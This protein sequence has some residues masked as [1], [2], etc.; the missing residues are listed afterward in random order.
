VLSSYPGEQPWGSI[1][2]IEA[3]DEEGKNVLLNPPRLVPRISPEELLA[4]Y[5]RIKAVD[6]TRPVFLT[7]NGDFFEG[8]SDYDETTRKRLYPQYFQAADV[9]GYDIYPIFGWGYPSRLTWIAEAT[10]ELVRLAG[11]RPVY[12]WIE[13]NKGSRW[14]SPE[15]QIDVTPQHTRAEVWMAIIRGAT[16]VGYFTHQ[17]VPNYHQFAPKEP[18]IS[19]LRRLNEQLTRLAPAILAE[20]ARVKITMSLGDGLPCH[21]KATV[22]EG[23]LYIFAQNIDL[24]PESEKKRQFEPIEPRGGRAVFTVEGLKVGTRIEV[25]DEDRSIIAEE[26]RF[27]DYFAPLAEHIYRLRL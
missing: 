22:Y 13:T 7:S 5:H 20:P 16:A 10:E 11:H 17:W 23:T 14:I 15:K 3:F 9:V 12:A 24:G 4:Q 2:E 27:T 21:F 19:A 18:M 1:G 25:I 26:G 8:V 6:K